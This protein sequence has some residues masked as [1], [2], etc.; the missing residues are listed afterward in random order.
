M[1]TPKLIKINHLIQ[2]FRQKI[3]IIVIGRST[4]ITEI[5]EKL[6]EKKIYRI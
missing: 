4:S 3:S 2:S 6:T 5:D 1:S